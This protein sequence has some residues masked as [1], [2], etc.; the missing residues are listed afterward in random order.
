MA[1]PEHSG[2]GQSASVWKCTNTEC[3]GEFQS[4]VPGMHYCSLCG[5]KLCLNLQVKVPQGTPTAGSLSPDVH[6][7]TERG[8]QLA[9]CGPNLRE[10]ESPTTAVHSPTESQ[11]GNSCHEEQQASSGEG[12]QNPNP[13][14][15]EGT[16]PSPSLTQSEDEMRNDYTLPTQQTT[17]GSVE[18]QV[19]ANITVD[20]QSTPVEAHT[21]PHKEQQASPGDSEQSPGRLSEAEDEAEDE[22]EDERKDDNTL[23]SQQTTAS[24]PGSVEYQV[25]ARIDSKPL[26]HQLVGAGNS[27]QDGDD[28]P[29]LHIEQVFGQKHECDAKT[30]K[31]ERKTKQGKRQRDE[32]EQQEDQWKE[33]KEQ[34][35]MEVK[36]RE[37]QKAKNEKERD[38]KRRRELQEKEK[39]GK[40][41]QQKK[42]EKRKREQQE[43]EEKRKGE[44]QEK[45]EK[46][47]RELQE[48]EKKEQQKKEEKRKREQ[49][50]KEEKR[51]GEQQEKE[52]KRKR[53]LQQREEVHARQRTDRQKNTATKN[54]PL[55]A[56]VN[57]PDNGRSVAGGSG[58]T[59]SENGAESH[60]TSG[61][62]EQVRHGL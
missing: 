13:S 24:S 51:K 55:Q 2:S 59:N 34:R 23:P 39:K 32:K 27:N 12:Q 60:D 53:E 5:A 8:A 41:E 25:P 36:E 58:N 62:T 54:V 30:E 21:T 29:Q 22:T 50:E 20:F 52:E 28:T 4:G 26:D 40:I 37:D 14:E 11:S 17:T 56:K 61:K 38:E 9:D 35:I 19:T 42:E 10:N 43:K 16:T 1:D 44:Q 49:Q 47:R 3:G 31:D 18:Y 45:E 48:K 33:R 15:A 7:K 6:E 57:S 46:R